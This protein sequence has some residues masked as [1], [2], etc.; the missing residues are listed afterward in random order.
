MK[1]FIKSNFGVPGLEQEALELDRPEMTLREFLKKLSEM[2]PDRLEYVQP[3]A[4]EVD[5]LAWDVLINDIPYENY[6]EGLE[7]LLVNGDV[8]TIRI[9][10]VGGG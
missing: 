9:K 8:V 10:P 1:I 4:K 6:E 3:G 5:P 7:H 2:S